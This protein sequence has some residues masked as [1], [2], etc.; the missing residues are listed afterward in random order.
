MLCRRGRGEGARLSVQL[1]H[2]T[3]L[4][5]QIHWNALW[6]NCI[7]LRQRIFNPCG[8]N[9][10][11]QSKR[12]QYSV[13]ANTQA[14]TVPSGIRSVDDLNRFVDQHLIPMQ[15]DL[16]IERVMHNNAYIL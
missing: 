8:R 1:V 16:L 14:L 3:G 15:E 13:G 10:L 6:R 12:K 2:D 5:A 9:L 4:N 7:C 11:T